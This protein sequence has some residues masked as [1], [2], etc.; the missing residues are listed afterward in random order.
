MKTK[1]AQQRILAVAANANNA[2]LPANQDR[3]FVSVSGPSPSAFY[4][5]FGV[6]NQSNASG[7]RYTNSQQPLM[8]RKED[9]GALIEQQLNVWNAGSAGFVSIIEGFH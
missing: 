1:R 6:E 4:V 5:S 9:I 7:D 2:I 3:T 8:Y